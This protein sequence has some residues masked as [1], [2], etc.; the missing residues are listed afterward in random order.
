MDGSR[1]LHLGPWGNGISGDE[2]L[3]TELIGMQSRSELCLDIS[4]T[5]DIDEG[6]TV[7]VRLTHSINI[8]LLVEFPS[9]QH[10]ICGDLAST[11]EE[12]DGELV[13]FT[14]SI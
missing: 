3:Y 2:V 11:E 4:C 8:A 12:L 5:D 1:K 7:W 6:D 13:N 14:L 10:D 9:W